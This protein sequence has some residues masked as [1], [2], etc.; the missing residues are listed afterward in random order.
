MLRDTP[1][2]LRGMGIGTDFGGRLWQY[3]L[4]PTVHTL[5][6]SGGGE[7]DAWKSSLQGMK[8]VM[9]KEDPCPGVYKSTQAQQTEVTFPRTVK[10]S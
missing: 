4:K 8:G 3:L 5:L 2:Q 1:T 9:G 10:T 6:Q 7:E